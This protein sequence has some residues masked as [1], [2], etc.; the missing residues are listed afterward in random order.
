[1]DI[2]PQLIMNS[3]IAGATYTMIAL[4]FNLI[5]GTVKFFDLDTA[6]LSQSADIACISFPTFSD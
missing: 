3:L 2:L 6:R 1:M 5:Y 4:G